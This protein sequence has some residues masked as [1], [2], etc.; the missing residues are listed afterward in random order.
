MSKN[1]FKNSLNKSYDETCNQAKIFKNNFERKVDTILQR[2][3]KYVKLYFLYKII[4][5]QNSLQ[6]KS[7]NNKIHRKNHKKQL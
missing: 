2:G 5:K 6:T 7:R 3:E 4:A 1:L